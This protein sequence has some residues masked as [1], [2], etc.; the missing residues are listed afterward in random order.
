ML[1]CKPQ[2]KIRSSDSVS[3]SS[4]GCPGNDL[5]QQVMLSHEGS[6]PVRRGR[7]L[8]LQ[9]AFLLF[10]EQS[11]PDGKEATQLGPDAHS[12]HPGL[13]LLLKTRRQIS[14]G[15][16]SDNLFKTWKDLKG[17]PPALS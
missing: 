5:V 10:T 3:T 9:T 11:D 15:Y 14:G 17:P 16:P 1:P 2:A 6:L 7:A 12:L 13:N 4:C 8:C